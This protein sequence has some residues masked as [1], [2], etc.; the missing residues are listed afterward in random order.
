[1]RE[2]GLLEESI[3]L[4]PTPQSLVSEGIGRLAPLWLL[5]TPGAAGLADIVRSAGVDLDLEHALAVERASEPCRWVEVN[6][7]MMLHDGGVP[8]PEVLAY[9]ER[10]GV[11]SP[12]L[13]AHLVRFMKE[14]TSRTYVMNYPVGLR[15]CSSFVDGDPGR[16]RRLLT[17]QV[18]V[19]DLLEASGGST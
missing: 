5:D 3:V 2:R 14:P 16:F 19:R 15:L 18:R 6:A 7:A 13:A 11:L 1:V 4:V 10:W 9:L 8:E 12:D 17:E